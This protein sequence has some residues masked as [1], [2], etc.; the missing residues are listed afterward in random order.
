MRYLL[1]PQCGAHRFFVKDSTGSAVYFHVDMQQ[2]PVPTGE[3]AAIL[4]GHGFSV[5]YCCGCS[6]SGGL[7]KLVRFFAG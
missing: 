1:C 3:S 6:W 5:I 4:D 2:Q 7:H